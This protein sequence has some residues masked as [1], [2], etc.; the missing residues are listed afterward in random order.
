[1]RSTCATSCTPTPR[2]PG[3]RCG[4]PSGSPPPSACADAPTVAGTGRLVRRR[5]RRR[6][7]RRGACRARRAAAARAESGVRVRRRRR[8]DA[9]LRPRRAPRRP[10]GAGPVGARPTRCPLALLAVLQPRE[11]LSPSGPRTWWPPACSRATTCA[12]S[13]ARTSSRGCPPARSRPTRAWSTPRS[14]SSSCTVTGNGG[15]GA[16]PHLADDT[17]QRAERVRAGR[18]VAGPGGRRPDAGVRRVV[19][20][21][22]RGRRRQRDPGARQRHRDPA[23][24]R[25]RRPGAD[26]GPAARRGAHR[27]RD[28]RLPGRAARAVQ[29]AAAGQRRQ[30]WPRGRRTG[31]TPSAPDGA[32]RSARRAPTTSPTTPTRRRA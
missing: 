13:S 15:H 32:R 16:Y 21:A 17:R 5:P 20:G 2:C 1:M 31:W 26:A 22:A 14:T 9:R 24:V 29:R 10:G 3:R 19:R 23:R 6:P 28:L 4:P 18:T 27:R 25:R 7:R 8:R 12:R 30:R 11:E